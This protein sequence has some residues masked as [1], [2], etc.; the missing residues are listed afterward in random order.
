MEHIEIIKDAIFLIAIGCGVP[1]W[2]ISE[3]RRGRKENWERFNEIF[4]DVGKQLAELKKQM[5]KDRRKIDEK[6][7]HRECKRL[8]ASN[9]CP[10]TKR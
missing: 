9:R 3:V 6:V 10:A 1:I 8:R 7:S 5:Q 4:A 2:I